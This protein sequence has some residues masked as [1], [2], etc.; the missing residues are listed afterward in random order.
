MCRLF[1]AVVGVF[2][3][4]VETSSPCTDRYS[5]WVTDRSVFIRNDEPKHMQGLHVVCLWKSQG[6]FMIEAYKNA[7]EDELM[8][9]HLEKS[10]FQSWKEFRKELKAAL[11]FTLRHKWGHLSL[12]QPFGV[13][14]ESGKRMS[15]PS[16]VLA[17]GLVLVFEGG[18]WFWPPI[19]KGYVR[20]LPGTDFR[21]ETLSVQPVVYKVQGFLK[22]EECDEI[23]KL[24]DGHMFESPVS[25]MDKD[26]GKAAKEFRTST[27]ARVSTSRS[28]TLQKIDHRVANLTRIPNT[29]NEEVQIL[30][31]K[32][33]Q[34][35]SAHL[36]NWDPA[37]IP[38]AKLLLWNMVGGTE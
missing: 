8:R 27:Q 12:R 2:V 7:V 6:K 17:A 10:A 30:R 20:Q 32:E 26:K 35:Y 34:Y 15:K 18:Q 9:K 3:V 37:S 29:H 31:Y 25:L 23:I 28:T 14:S 24:G 1:A 11:G 36:D 13:Y 4:E 22:H 5:S 38:V 16:E 21:L 33:T 19:R